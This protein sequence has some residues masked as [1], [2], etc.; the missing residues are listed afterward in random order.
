MAEWL[1]FRFPEFDKFGPKVKKTMPLGHSQPGTRHRPFGAIFRVPGSI[2]QEPSCIC[3]DYFCFFYFSSSLFSK[4]FSS[5]TAGPM[6]LKYGAKILCGSLNQGYKNCVDSIPTLATRGPNVKILKSFSWRPLW[7]RSAEFLQWWAVPW[8]VSYV[9]FWR[10][11]GFVKW[12]F[13][14]L[15]CFL[16]PAIAS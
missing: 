4:I 3:K 13:G 6:D 14:P 10:I 2:P 7:A 1:P 5:E 8:V 9:W 15:L 16:G 12:P 11:S